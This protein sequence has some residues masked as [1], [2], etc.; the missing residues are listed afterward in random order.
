M[1]GRRNEILEA[2]SYKI[3]ESLRAQF[4]MIFPMFIDPALKKTVEENM[5]LNHKTHP[6]AKKYGSQIKALDVP[7]CGEDDPDHKICNKMMEN[8]ARL[9]AI[10]LLIVLCCCLMVTGV[11]IVTAW[12]VRDAAVVEAGEKI[13]A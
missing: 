3:R 1:V 7:D 4:N 5:W 13:T 10:I 2:K 9:L 12:K 8:P 11:G 6:F